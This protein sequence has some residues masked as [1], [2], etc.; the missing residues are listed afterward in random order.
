LPDPLI[1]VNGSL[2]IQAFLYIRVFPSAANKDA[3]ASQALTDYEKKMGTTDE[4]RSK[5]EDRGWRIA[6][7]IR[8]NL[9]SS[10]LDPQTIC[11]HL[12]SSVVPFF[13]SPSASDSIRQ[14]IETPL[15]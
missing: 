3:A 1:Q 7:S 11:V 10:I 14:L 6:D 9:L 4:H 12:C 15:R 13:V 8:G 5:I 2:H